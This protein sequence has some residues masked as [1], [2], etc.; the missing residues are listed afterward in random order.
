MV[1]DPRTMPSQGTCGREA[2]WA[3]SPSEDDLTTGPAT[4]FQT[5]GTIV[6]FRA[7]PHVQVALSGDLQRIFRHHD[8]RF[9]LY[10]PDSE[11]SRVATGRLPLSRSSLEL[12]D[13]Y[14]LAVEWR[15][16]TDGL[17]DPQNPDGGLD[18]NGVVKAHAIEQ[19]GEFLWQEGEHDWS[20]NC[21]GDIL[22]SGT[23]SPGAPW[24]IGISDPADRSAM[25]ASVTTSPDRMAIATSGVSERGHHI[26]FPTTTTTGKKSRSVVQVSVAAAD[27]LTADVIATA[28]YAGGTDSLQDMA[29]RFKVD[30][31]TI[32][33]DGQTRWTVERPPADPSSASR[34]PGT[35]AGFAFF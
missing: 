20:L 27:I 5:M 6:S 23:Q 16:V 4:T 30:I 3:S 21:G 17:F 2:D 15:S 8:E 33:A 18:L 1:L 25:V 35:S 13:M 32:D 11:L 14:A 28:I 19:A 34:G 22:C 10:K 9:S 12:R 24:L 31:F 29:E 26:W 7:S